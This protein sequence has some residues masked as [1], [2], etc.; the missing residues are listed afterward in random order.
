MHQSFNISKFYSYGLR[1]Q[2]LIPGKIWAFFVMFHIFM[3]MNTN[4]TVLGDMTLYP[5]TNL[6]MFRSN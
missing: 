5:G 1:D 3:A 4:I 2:V 6:V